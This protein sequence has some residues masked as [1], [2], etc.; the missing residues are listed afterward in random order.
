MSE[1]IKNVEA[2]VVEEKETANQQTNSNKQPD[3]KSTGWCILAFLIPI[4]GLIAYL[5]WNKEYPI[6]SKAIGKWAIIGAI[7]S[8]IISTISA[9]A[10]G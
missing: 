6:K 10:N 9:C 8:V 5:I 3:E 4:A 1:E 2:E 7:A